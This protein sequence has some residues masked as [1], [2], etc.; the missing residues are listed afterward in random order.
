MTREDA[1]ELVERMPY[2]RTIQAANDKARPELYRIALDSEDP[3]EWIKVIKSDYI[4]RNDRT[5]RRFPSPEEGRIAGEAREKLNGMLSGALEIP[6]DGM[7]RFIEDY[8][9]QTQ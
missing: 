1:L 6:K 9:R 3:V 8:I 5:A 2:I 4:R 7:D